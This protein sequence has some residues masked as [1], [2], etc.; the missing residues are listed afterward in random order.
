[1]KCRPVSAGNLPREDED[2]ELQN[3][4]ELPREG[5]PGRENSV[6]R[7]PG[8]RVWLDEVG[9][10]ERS[11]VVGGRSTGACPLETLRALWVGTEG[12]SE[13]W[14]CCWVRLGFLV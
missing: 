13:R 5:F 12:S 3:E 10:R 6:S 8:A 14:V 7:F 4:M 1:M 11:K 9:K 2:E